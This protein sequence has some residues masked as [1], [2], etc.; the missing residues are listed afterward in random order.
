MGISA[1]VVSVTAAFSK[2]PEHVQSR[3]P[4]TE[5]LE[6]TKFKVPVYHGSLGIFLRR[7]FAES[8]TASLLKSS[9]S[10]TGSRIF[11]IA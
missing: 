5:L 1:S 6:K 9:L 2:I 11:G 7:R 3:S 4:K 8:S 10:F